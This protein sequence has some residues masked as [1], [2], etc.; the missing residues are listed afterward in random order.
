MARPRRPEREGELVRIVAAELPPCSARRQAVAI[1]RRVA[2]EVLR[3]IDIPPGD[4][5]ALTRELSLALAP[6]PVSVLATCP[7]IDTGEVARTARL[8]LFEARGCRHLPEAEWPAERRA[9]LRDVE[10]VLANRY[11]RH[12]CSKSCA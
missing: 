2:A 12:L 7:E 11:A 9:V 4:L 1:A 6:S 10:R 5:R 3:D 8:R